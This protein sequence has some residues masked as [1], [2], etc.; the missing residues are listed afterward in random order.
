ML[1][2]SRGG[3]LSGWPRDSVPRMKS[4]LASLLLLVQ[5][6]PVL[7]TVA[8]FG[9]SERAALQECRMAE[10]G[11]APTSGFTAAGATTHSCELAT[12]CMPAPLAIP[13]FS[14]G[15]ETAIVLHETAVSL[16]APSPRD[17]SPAP[18]FHPPRA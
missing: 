1:P 9:L 6:Q 7:G 3:L 14:S 12:L 5:L 4:V 8:C 18:P 11:H 13:G 10:H 16:T 17:I 15:L 2:R